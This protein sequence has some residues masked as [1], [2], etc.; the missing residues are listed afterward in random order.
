[1]HSSQRVN[2]LLQVTDRVHGMGSIIA[3]VFVC[4]CA[5]Q[6][7]EL[8]AGIGIDK[9][10]DAGSRLEQGHLEAHDNG[11]GALLGRDSAQ[12]SHVF[13]AE[14]EHGLAGS[15]EIGT[16]GVGY[17]VA[18]GAPV[19]NAG[20]DVQGVV[21]AGP[22]LRRLHFGDEGGELFAAVR[23]EPGPQ[24]PYRGVE[25]AAER[26]GGRDS[27]RPVRPGGYEFPRVESPRSP[28]VE[29]GEV[30]AGLDNGLGG[31]VPAG[32]AV[33]DAVEEE[34]DNA[35]GDCAGNGSGDG[36]AEGNDGTVHWAL[37]F[38]VAFTVAFV[39]A[40]LS[41]LTAAAAGRYRLNL[42]RGRGRGK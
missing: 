19:L 13:G 18:A 41:G 5:C 34:R 6:A 33:L 17:L 38:A 29:G 11:A 26:M 23:A 27:G 30:G 24:L 7:V 14:R 40:L 31:G 12:Y 16:A 32:T 42:Y 28:G 1:M 22:G 37:P 36:A 15:G 8:G 39:T 20:E 2:K 10:I 35:A 25:T 3:A 9:G 4:C 21:P